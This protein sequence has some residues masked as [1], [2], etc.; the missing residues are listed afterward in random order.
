MPTEKLPKVY[1]DL[2]AQVNPSSTGA[3]CSVCW[4]QLALHTSLPKVLNGDPEYLREID[5]SWYRG[6]C[7]ECQ[8]CGAVYETLTIVCNR[9]VQ[10]KDFTQTG[11]SRSSVYG[12]L[13]TLTQTTLAGIYSISSRFSK[14]HNG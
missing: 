7:W 14:D 9:L 4:N 2:G 12:F 5:S 13:A 11:S 10:E 1:F 6:T 8:S 3:G